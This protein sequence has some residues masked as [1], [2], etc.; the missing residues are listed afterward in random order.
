M[1]ALDAA[2]AAL[3]DFAKANKA[4]LIELTEVSKLNAELTEERRKAATRLPA[5]KAAQDRAAKALKAIAGNKTELNAE[6]AKIETDARKAHEEV[7]GDVKTLYSHRDKGR[8]AA[9]AH[10]A[11][12]SILY[13]VQKRSR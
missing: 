12:S 2:I 13:H 7:L 10:D 3:A 9:K 1:V 5:L 11:N 8:V 4:V 6:W